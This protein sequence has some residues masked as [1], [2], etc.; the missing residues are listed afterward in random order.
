MYALKNCEGPH[1]IHG[2]RSVTAK[3][4]NIQKNY[5]IYFFSIKL[6]YLHID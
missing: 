6:L 5:N 3:R 2:L 4:Q 1:R